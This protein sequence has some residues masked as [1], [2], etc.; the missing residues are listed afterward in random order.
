LIVSLLV[1]RYALIER[2]GE[3]AT[4]V[5]W[6]AHDQK[7]ERDV[8][9]KVLRPLVASDAEQRQR[10]AREARLLAQLSNDHIVRVFDYVDD[11]E[12]VFL[13]MEHVD[14]VNLVD[15]TSRALPLAVDEAAAYLTPVAEALAYAHGQGVVHRDLTPANILIERRSGR[16]VTTDFGLARLARSSSTLTATGT[17]IGTPEYWSPEQALGRPADFATDMYALGCIVFLLLTGRLPFEGDDRLAVGLQRA[18]EAA[19]SLGRR[20]RHAPP[21][22]VE[23][24][25]SLLA[26]EPADR[27]AARAV[28]GELRAL[29]RGTRIPVGAA[30]KERNDAATVV[31]PAERATV[32][33]PPR[34]A[35][36][37]RR[38]RPA[39]T[40]FAISGAATLGV[41]A[42]VNALTGSVLRAPRLVGL[43]ETAARAQV[44]QSL[45]TTPI[46]VERA[47]SVRVARGRVMHQA[48]NAG[49]RVRGGSPIRLVVSKGTPF[50]AVPDVAVGTPRA[51]ANITLAG[52]GFTTRYR[53]TPS[54]TVRK[55]TVI[56]L[57]PHSGTRLRRPARIRILIASGYP[58]AVVPN[59]ENS[60]LATAQSQLAAKHL[61]FHVV[62]RLQ[63]G[64]PPNQVLHQIPAAGATVYRGTRVR[65]TVARTLRWQ[66]VF[67][68]SGI[69]PFQSQPFSVPAHWRIR[70]RVSAGHF[71]AGLAQV[72][73]SSDGSFTEDRS[74]VTTAGD[75]VETHAVPD[76]AGTFVLAVAPYAATAWYVEVD[77]LR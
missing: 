2:I 6:L 1:A 51:T 48:P 70:T 23:L 39:L 41:F 26:H 65:L 8:A 50:A 25:D 34:R 68:Q 67:T 61:Q 33:V 46:E 3:G 21:A 43:R 38:W 7:L 24:V 31:L 16:V 37:R 72:A 28:A 22:V 40:A 53:Y 45:P 20:L 17:L 18:H 64:T 12:Q 75:R 44:Q 29:A 74:F 58:R 9:I 56:E 5:V 47:Y 52:A 69:G 4:G 27:P 11:G 62:Y 32:V 63:H 14:G 76:G 66:R 15:A 42:L 54:W 77:A 13:V 10:F 73:W 49:A 36:G 59:V 19:P 57:Q 71:G 55:G 60:D 35:A 30:G